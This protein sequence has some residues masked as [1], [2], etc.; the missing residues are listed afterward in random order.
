VLLQAQAVALSLTSVFMLYTA[1]GL[2][3]N[4]KSPIVARHCGS[5]EPGIHRGDLLFLSNS[6]PQ[7]YRTGE[8]TVYQVTSEGITIV[9]RVVQTHDAADAS[10]PLLLTKGD[11][12]DLDDLSLYQG[13]EWLERK[14]VV[15]RVRCIIPLVGYASILVNE[16]PRLRYGILGVVGILNMLHT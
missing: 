9:H 10:S 15:G 12:N 8:I 13:L 14:H 2:L 7:T 16:Y 6:M 4:C 11:N 1:L 3:T 5:M